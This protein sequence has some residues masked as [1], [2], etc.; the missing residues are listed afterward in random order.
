M[1]DLPD[2][3]ID[4]QPW[5]A[6]PRT[7][8]IRLVVIHSTRG[9]TTQ[10]LQYSA[11]KNWLMSPGNNQ[12]GWG[13]STNRIISHEG[14]MCVCWSD[15]M[16]PTYSAGFGFEG[17]HWAIDWY[18]VSFELAQRTFSEEFAEPTLARTA[19]EVALLCAKYSI[20]PVWL[21]HVDQTGAVPV[22]ITGHE[23][24]DNGRRLGKTDPGSDLSA[25]GRFDAPA[26]IQRVLREMAGTPTLAAS[27]PAGPPT[28]GRMHEVT[29]GENLFRI[30]ILYYQDGSRWP[31]IFEA[32]REIIGDN[33]SSIR[34]GQRLIIPDL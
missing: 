29:T 7:H 20:P 8:P 27:Q 24:T 18:A 9:D 3:R 30:A 13:G 5:L 6:V 25:G 21:D 1:T 34:I 19:R 14:Q 22:G 12:G 32:N 16:S 23:T 11:T 26:F 4:P 31:A 2:E 15:D 28:G 17:S 10:E 33:P